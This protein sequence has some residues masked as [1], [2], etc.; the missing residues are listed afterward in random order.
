[1]IL[2]V[3]YGGFDLGRIEKVKRKKNKIENEIESEIC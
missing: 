1:L 2:V 3:A